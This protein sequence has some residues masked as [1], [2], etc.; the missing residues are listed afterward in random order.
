M[1]LKDILNHK[2]KLILI[3]IF[4]LFLNNSFGQSWEIVYDS[5]PSMGRQ[6]VLTNDDCYMVTSTNSQFD[7]GI[8]LKIDHQGNIL[9]VT[10]YGGMSI[11]QTYDNGYIIASGKNYSDAILTKLDINGNLE[12]FNTYGGGNQDEFESVIQ[13][14]DSCFVA[15]GFSQS[16]GDSTLFIVKTDRFGNLLWKRSFNCIDYGNAR[17]L[18]E[19]DNQ[20]YIVG[21]HGDY[22]SDYF[23]FIARLN[24]DGTTVWRKDYQVGFTWY[25]IAMTNDSS[26]VAVG[27][28]NLTKLDLNGE[29]LWSKSLDESWGIYSVDI[30]SDNGFILSGEIA[31][32]EWYTENLLVRA[33]SAGN[34]LW[35][36][37][38][39]NGYDGTPKTFESVKSTINNGYIACGYSIY[40]DIQ[41]LRIITTDLDGNIVVKPEFNVEPK[42]IS[43]FPNPTSGKSSISGKD[44]KHVEVYNLVGHK[45][46][47]I[48]GKCEIDISDEPN[49]IY[50]VKILTNNGNYI[51]K[52]LKQ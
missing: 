4:I 15:C 38:Y 50:I 34:I 28:N 22:N 26:L 5:I 14:S 51:E 7:L 33:D 18:I 12:W 42:T 1:R 21:H 48:M 25:S 24:S 20:Y 30:T 16:Y 29:I 31:C 37:T 27:R 47:S 45:V 2:S 49:G 6:V 8:S 17:D 44:I 43:I 11:Q 36:Q 19:I 32:D 9:W 39:P 41:K 35:H 23:L 13:A 40:D 46:L 52:I 10:S 3:I